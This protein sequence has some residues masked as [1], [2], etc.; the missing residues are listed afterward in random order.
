MNTTEANAV[1]R[2]LDWILDTRTP[3][4][5]HVTDGE[6]MERA[7]WLADRAHLALRAGGTGESVLRQW[8]ERRP[9]VIHD[10][11]DGARAPLRVVLDD[12]TGG[13]RG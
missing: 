12:E 4:G 6:A 10:C 2:L 7:A 13:G 8:R 5:G 11:P 3:S 1:N 9:Y